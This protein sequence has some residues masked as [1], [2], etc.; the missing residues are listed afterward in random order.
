MTNAVQPNR[1][2]LESA[3]IDIRNATPR[4]P[5]YNDIYFSADGSLT[6]SRHVFID[7]N[8]LRRRFAGWS[9]RRPFVIGETGFGTGRNV[10]VAWQTFTETAP[11]TARLHIVSFERH[12]LRMQ[13]LDAVW[14]HHPGLAAC[15]DQLARL[16]PAPTRG[17][18]RL[19]LSNRVTLDLIFDD[20]EAGLAGFDGHVDAW[21]LDGFAP[22]RNPAMWSQRVFH[23]L[24]AASRPAATFATY[25]CARM[26]R[27][28]AAT[29]GFVWYKRAGA[30]RKRD[31]LCGWLDATTTDIA[32]KRKRRPW[33][34][35][36]A[37]ASS[38]PIAVIGA[39]IAG[40]TVAEALARRGQRCDVY[41]PHRGPGGASA[42]SQAALYIRPAANG[43][44]RTV[45]TWLRW[46][47][48]AAGWPGSTRNA[49]SGPTAACCNSHAMTAKPNASS[50]V[51]SNSGY[52][53]Q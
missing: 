26:V 2:G 17:T 39:G 42:N 46:N 53:R 43:G 48:A 19:H 31:M 36:P 23:E 32:S 11:A 7:G 21:F 9:D 38:G 15:A 29:A 37:I 1:L 22:S 24:A 40:A 41:D 14:I 49:N 50:V 35:P 18:H 8:D 47:T 12:P 45:S 30:G 20:I 4:A 27:K 13:D 10:L 34:Q 3:T 28:H 52:L 5:D 44:V 33:Y 6:E 51:S 16:W 25:S